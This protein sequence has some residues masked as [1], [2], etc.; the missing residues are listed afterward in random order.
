MPAPRRQEQRVHHLQLTIA[1][2]GEAHRVHDLARIRFAIHLSDHDQP[3]MPAASPAADAVMPPG[4]RAG[5]GQLGGRLDVLRLRIA[6]VDDDGVLQPAR[7][8]NR[9]LVQNARSP[10]RKQRRPLESPRSSP[11]AAARPP[12]DAISRSASG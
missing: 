3:S 12:P 6:A 8:T 10:E 7:M 4:R 5:V 1:Q 9:P 2:H 11:A